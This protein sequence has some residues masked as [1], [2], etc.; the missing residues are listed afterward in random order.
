MA[1]GLFHY[2]SE[3]NQR[4]LFDEV[5]RREFPA[6]GYKQ[7]SLFWSF[8]R[9]CR[10]PLQLEEYLKKA[11]SSWEEL[12]GMHHWLFWPFQK[13]LCFYGDSAL[14][15]RETAFSVFECASQMLDWIINNNVPTVPGAFGKPNW[16]KWTLA[17][18]LYGL[19]VREVIPDFLSLEDG[20][21]CEIDLALKLQEQLRV[22]SILTTPIPPLAL[23]GINVGPNPP[24][25]GGLVLRF[26]EARAD[27]S[28]LE[29]AGGI[30]LSS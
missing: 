23:A 2:A 13:S 9:V 6:T 22:P 24:T 15:S 5:M 14:I 8:G 30:G 3:K 20:P 16:K 28:D 10:D 29:L 21:A 12:S 17:A 1:G 4:C 18:I 7:S 19:R 25:L 27:D 26:L 11:I